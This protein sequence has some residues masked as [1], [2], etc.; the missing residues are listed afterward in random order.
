MT[1]ER[2]FSAIIGV[3]ASLAS[4]IGF[5]VLGGQ[6]EF[7]EPTGFDHRV[8]RLAQGRELDAARIALKPLFPVGLPGGYITIAYATARWIHRRQRHGSP[9]IVTAAWL[10]WLVHRAVKGVYFRARP[11]KPRVR[12]RVDS[13]PSG[14]TT[15]T[16]S[17]AVAAALVLRREGLISPRV[18]AAVGLGAPVLMGAH[19]V[20]ADDHWMTDV[21]GGWLLGTAIGVTCYAALGEKTRRAPRVVRSKRRD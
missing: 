14:H 15:G 20:L 11:P 7:D 4:A 2:S 5:A 16:T 1:E 19:R 3:P 8:R 6:L 9:A 10:G 12:R 17:F 13:Y 21:I 18:A